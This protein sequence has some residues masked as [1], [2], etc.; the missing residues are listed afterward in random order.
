MLA[1]GAVVAAGTALR[2]AQRSGE[3]GLA[4]GTI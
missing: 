1:T 4:P 3:A 2:G